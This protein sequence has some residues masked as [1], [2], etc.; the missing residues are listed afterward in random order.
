MIAKLIELLGT[1]KPRVVDNRNT[2]IGGGVLGLGL[3]ALIAQVETATGCHFKE[4]FMGLD[5]M[6]I[7]SGTAVAVFGALTTDAHKTV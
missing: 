6:Q 1:L 2:T 4:A 3:M 5:W 7:I